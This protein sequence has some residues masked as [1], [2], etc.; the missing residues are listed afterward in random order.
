MKLEQM[1]RDMV[2]ENMNPT[3][4]KVN[5][6]ENEIKLA[7][8]IGLKEIQ[9]Q[10]TGIN[11]LEV[12]SVMAP[13][14]PLKQQVEE[15][16]VSLA[17]LRQSIESFVVDNQ[18]DAAEEPEEEPEAEAEPEDEDVEDE[19]DTEEEPEEEEPEVETDDTSDDD[20]KKEDK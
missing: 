3:T 10:L 15:F 11:F 14:N 2:M 4:T 6:Q 8:I 5:L 12:I 19:D 7:A 9:A 16:E 13:E 18:F 1:V 17:S 20:E